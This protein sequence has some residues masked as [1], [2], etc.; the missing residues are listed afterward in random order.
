M[1]N[2]KDWWNKEKINKIDKSLAKWS[3]RKIE[4]RQM[5]KIRV[6]KQDVT[7]GT[8]EIQR[9]NSKYFEN[10]YFNTLKNLE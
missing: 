2:T 5:S 3:K 9:I 8:T 7:I 1:N 4:N 6:E 10:L